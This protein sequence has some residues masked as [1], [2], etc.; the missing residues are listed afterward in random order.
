MP[1]IGPEGCKAL[2]KAGIRT[3]LQLFGKAMQL[4]VPGSSTQEHANA[5]YG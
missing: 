5:L 1:G 4:K 2:I 3:P